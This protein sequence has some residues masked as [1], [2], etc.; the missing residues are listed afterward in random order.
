M[1]NWGYRLV[2]FRRLVRENLVCQQSITFS[3]DDLLGRLKRIFI[4]ITSNV[5][6]RLERFIELFKIFRSCHKNTADFESCG[7][8]F[9]PVAQK[10]LNMTKLS[11]VMM[12]LLPIFD[13]ELEL[14]CITGT[15]RMCPSEIY[16]NHHCTP[17]TIQEIFFR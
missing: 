7:R 9:E 3:K 8:H 16:R 13:Q 5:L 12:L 1:N 11:I 2:I 14:W 10:H 15:V 17:M 6:L 4:I